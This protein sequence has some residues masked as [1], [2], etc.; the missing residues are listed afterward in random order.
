MNKKLTTTEKLDI[1]QKKFGRKELTE[2]CLLKRIGT[3]RIITIKKVRI[4]FKRYPKFAWCDDGRDV[5]L[6]DNLK[7]NYEI[8]GHPLTFN[9]V[10]AAIQTKNIDYSLTHEKYIQ[11]EE[12]EGRKESELNVVIE[13][14]KIDAEPVRCVSKKRFIWN[15]AHDL[16]RDQKPETIDTIY[17]ILIS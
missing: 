16:L 17:K 4:P 2:G 7:R 1:L 8:I 6:D 3:G 5:Y 11:N 13:T 15:L 9:N 10:L 14:Y 12:L